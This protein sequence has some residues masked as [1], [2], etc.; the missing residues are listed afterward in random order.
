MLTIVV[1]PVRPLSIAEKRLI[2]LSGGVRPDVAILTR[3]IFLPTQT[4]P[5]SLSVVVHTLLRKLA[6]L[7]RERECAI[8]WNEVNCIPRETACFVSP[9]SWSCPVIILSR[10][11]T[12][13][14]TLVG[15]AKLPLQADLL[16]T[17]PT[18]CDVLMVW[19]LMLKDSSRTRDVR[20]F[21]M[22]VSPVKGVPRTL[23]TA[24]NFVPCNPSLAMPF[25]F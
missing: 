15:L 8:A 19:L 23:L 24:K 4:C 2:A 11:V 25:I 6:F 20:P 5:P 3:C 12:R 16:L 10:T 13:W 17:D 1:V 9:R 7:L 21:K 14:L 22:E 18:C